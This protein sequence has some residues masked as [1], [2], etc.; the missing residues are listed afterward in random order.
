[1]KTLYTGT[2]TR[3]GIETGSVYSI[4]T[5]TSDINYSAI[6]Q[7]WNFTL[8]NAPTD[9]VYYWGFTTQRINSYITDTTN[10]I[11]NEEIFLTI[12][13][14]GLV[15]G[16]LNAKTTYP[17]NGTGYVSSRGFADYSVF[18]GSGVLRNVKRVRIN[19]LENQSRTV[20]FYGCP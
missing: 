4:S 12:T 20:L 9:Y 7:I 11:L 17:D 15:V 19:F 5:E 13:Q 6:S 1:M 2:Y 16:A 8:D 14:A 3:T 18:T 10:S